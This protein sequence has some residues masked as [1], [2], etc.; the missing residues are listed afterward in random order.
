MTLQQ[1]LKQFTGV[2]WDV[3]D[4]E[5]LEKY[6]IVGGLWLAVAD[7]AWRQ[8]SLHLD[9]D[10]KGRFSVAVWANGERLEHVVLRGGDFGTLMPHVVAF[11]LTG[12]L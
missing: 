10:T 2:K 11:K 8:P 1:F 6:K 3:S 4:W 7:E 5:H 12:R 9:I